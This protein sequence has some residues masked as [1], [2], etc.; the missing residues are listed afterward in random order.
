MFSVPLRPV[1][2][3]RP[4]L[5]HCNND[6][7]NAVQ[8]AES[9]SSHDDPLDSSPGKY[10]FVKEQ[11]RQLQH[12]QLSEIANLYP[13]EVF[14]ERGN[15]IEAH[16]PDVPAQA[17]WYQSPVYQDSAGLADKQSEKYQV[18]IC[19][20]TGFGATEQLLGEP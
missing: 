14:A 6:K 3:D 17:I 7:D 4:A 13:V 2:G 19:G 10:P 18:I 11:E 15:L 12:R 9:D 20:H 1:I 8:D 5:E 16:R